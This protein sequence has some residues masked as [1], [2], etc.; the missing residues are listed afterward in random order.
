VAAVRRKVAESGQLEDEHA[1]ELQTFWTDVLLL[2]LE[3]HDAALAWS[4]KVREYVDG[5]RFRYWAQFARR[6]RTWRTVSSWE[7]MVDHPVEAAIADG[8][9]AELRTDRL[10]SRVEAEIEDH[11]TASS[12]RATWVLAVAVAVL[13]LF[14]TIEAIKNVFA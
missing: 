11:A 1:R 12:T 14:P 7:V 9:R 5:G 13:G 8:V 6:Y 2:E 3:Q 4:E 10:L